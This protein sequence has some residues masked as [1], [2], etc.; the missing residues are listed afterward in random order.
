MAQ[1]E[2]AAR[3]LMG[4]GAK[5]VIVTLGAQ[6]ALVCVEGK[7]AQLVEAFRRGAGA[8]DDGGGRCVLRRVCGGVE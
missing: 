3:V 4:R 1:A 5:C 7:A 6:G 8:G 2:A